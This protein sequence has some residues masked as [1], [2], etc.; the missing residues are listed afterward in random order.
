MLGEEKVNLV[1]VRLEGIVDA[2][3]IGEV[4]PKGIVAVLTKGREVIGK[5]LRFFLES[6]RARVAP[7]VL[8]RANRVVLTALIVKAVGDFVADD[9]ANGA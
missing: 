2:A 6:A 5:A 4:F 3:R 9:R 8:E 1:L 7:P